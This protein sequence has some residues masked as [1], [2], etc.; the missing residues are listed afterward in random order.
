MAEL[1]L[2]AK[3]VDALSVDAGERLEFWDEGLKGFGVRVSR[4]GKAQT[5]A[6]T[7]FVRYRV[8]TKMRRLSLGD[9]RPRVAG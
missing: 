5:T 9:A 4:R 2:T 7:Y 6:K 1:N 8:G 3:T